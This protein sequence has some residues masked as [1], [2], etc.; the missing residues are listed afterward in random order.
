M[1][2]YIFRTDFQHRYNSAFQQ[3]V[4]DKMFGGD[5]LVGSDLIHEDV[6]INEENEADEEKEPTG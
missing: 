6:E 5:I 1:K 4:V 2:S 3:Y